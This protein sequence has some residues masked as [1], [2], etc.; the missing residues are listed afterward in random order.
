MSILLN[1]FTAT[2]LNLSYGQRFTFMETEH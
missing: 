2:H 1:S